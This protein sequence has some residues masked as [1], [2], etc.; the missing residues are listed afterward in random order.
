VDLSFDQFIAGIEDGMIAALANVLSVAADSGY[1]KTITSYGGELDSSNLREAIGALVPRFPALLIS[2]AEGEDSLNPAT[3]PVQAGEPRHYRH[4]CTFTVLCLD[5]NARGEK[6]R[7]RGAPGS[8][9]LY[10][11]IGDVKSVLG[12]LKFSVT[13][14]EESKI[15]NGEGLRYANVDFI[16]RVPEMTAYA[17]HFDTWFR[18]GEVDRTVEGPLVQE[19]I[20]DVENTFPKG[21]SN[22]P[23]VSLR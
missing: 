4:D 8:V 11:M 3:Q 21:E 1:V 7:R 13:I 9:G 18:Y 14:G 22:L 12:G 5:A 19:L 10:R 2:Y 20:F 15:L 23:G 6:Q 16:A 17:V